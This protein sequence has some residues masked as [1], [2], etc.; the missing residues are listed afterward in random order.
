MLEEELQRI[1]QNLESE[2]TKTSSSMKA[3]IDKLSQ[4]VFYK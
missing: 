4:L 3:E 2:Y 1:R